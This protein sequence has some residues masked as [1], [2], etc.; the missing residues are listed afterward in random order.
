MSKVLEFIFHPKKNPNY[1]KLQKSCL[2]DALM[3]SLFVHPI[4]ALAIGVFEVNSYIWPES[5]GDAALLTSLRLSY[6]VMLVCL[7]LVE[8]LFLFI[9]DKFDERYRWLPLINTVMMVVWHLWALSVCH[10][11]YL[12]HGRAVPTLFIIISMCMPFCVYMDIRVFLGLTVIADLFQIN[13]YLSSSIGGKIIKSELGDFLVFIIIHFVLSIVIYYGKYAAQENILEQEAQKEEIRKLNQAQ[14]RFFS[15]M[16]HEIRTPINTI[17]GL[18][19]MILRQNVSEEI[20]EDA[21]NIQAASRMLLHLIND[22]LD[23]SKIESGQMELTL[24][25]YSVGDMLSDIVGMLWLRANEKD[26]A[27]HIEVAP[28]LPSQL[29]GDEMRIRQVLINVLNNS[30]KY[31]REGSVTLS[32]QSKKDEKGNAR[33]I[34]SVIDTGIGIKK[35]SIPHLFSAYKRVDNEKNKYIEGT[36]LG[37]SIVKQIV[38]LMGGTITVNSVYTKGSTF[39]IEIP[40]RII[41]DEPLG[42]FDA[43]RNRKDKKT[44]QYVKSFEAPEAKVLVVDDTATNILVV[45]KLLADTRVNLDTA[46]SGQEAL[47]KTLDNY[48]HVILMD[49]KMP[50]MDGI[51][52]LHAIRKQ[53]GGSCHESKV[54]ALTANAGSD[55]QNLYRKEGF[56]GYLMKPVRGEDLE[57]TVCHFLPEDIVTVTRTE[58]DATKESAVWVNEDIKRARIR[59]TTDSVADIPDVL[60]ERYNIEQIPHMIK[61]N[62][63]LFKDGLEIETDGLLAY[64]ENPG[65]KAEVVSPTEEEYSLFF[66]KQLDSANNIIHLAISGKVEHSGCQAAMEAAEDFGNVTVVDSGQLS[67]GQG[68]MAIEAARLADEGLEVS[69]IVARLEEMKDHVHTRFITDTLDYLVRQNQVPEPVGNLA[70]V[71]NAHIVMGLKKGKIG[72]AKIFFGSRERVWEKYIASAF[73]VHGTIDRR[74]LFITYSGMTTKELERIRQKVEAELTFDE[75]YVR[76]ASPGIATNCGPGT[77]G[78][79][80]FTNNVNNP[81]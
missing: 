66:S 52:C 77:F 61:T 25:P 19:E 62:E 76:K 38:D 46:S 10:L 44:Y 2:H 42:T 1:K 9:R 74:M 35:E 32:V 36:G 34:F 49:H 72:V 58:N 51:E 23:M 80:F 8:C 59:I 17:I 6:N 56:D 54:I 75:I 53:T 27:F 24:A 55:M 57:N 13:Y 15:N 67:S 79:L 39:V 20:N 26:L 29:E 68:L 48:Y 3:I 37:L 40:Q 47:K 50:G 73:R 7:L 28:D 30:I 22:I 69:Q 60:L 4:F 41:S 12:S 78:L 43:E 11:D 64:M 33:I 70:K 45:T 65:S 16:S 63:G 21:E 5:Y 71:F 14:N 18:N 31:T 81:A